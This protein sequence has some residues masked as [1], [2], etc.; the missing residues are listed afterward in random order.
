MSLKVD[1]LTYD[2]GKH[3]SNQWLI[4]E[5]DDDVLRILELKLKALNLGLNREFFSS[6]LFSKVKNTFFFS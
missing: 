1:C 3:L 5:D 6:Q 2:V 4:V